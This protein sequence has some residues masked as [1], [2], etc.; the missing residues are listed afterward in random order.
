MY[1]V[2][3]ISKHMN[4]RQQPSRYH[5][6]FLHHCMSYIVNVRLSKMTETTVKQITYLPPLFL[7]LFLCGP[8]TNVSPFSKS[9]ARLP[10][11]HGAGISMVF[12]GLLWTNDDTTQ[13]KLYPL[14]LTPY[15]S[16]YDNSL[17]F[18]IT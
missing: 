5:N 11:S 9:L 15:H 6:S 2:H 17:H 3:C 14:I 7:F 13:S 4:S 12:E 1:I 8:V 16:I 18:P 10:S